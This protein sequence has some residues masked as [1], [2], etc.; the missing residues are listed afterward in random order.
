[1]NDLAFIQRNDVFTNSW[2]VAENVGR[3]HASVTTSIKRF[4]EQFAKLG[5]IYSTA[6]RKNQRG[7]PTEIFDLNEAQA[8]FLMTLMD[9]NPVVIDFKVC[10][11]RRKFHLSGR[12][13]GRDGH[14]EGDQAGADGDVE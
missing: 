4:R 13:R 10:H 2:T 14:G 3:E 6:S 8:V 11:T 1:M 7:R 9:N 12:R 5:P